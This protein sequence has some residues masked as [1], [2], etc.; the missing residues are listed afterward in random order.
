M[1]WGK[2]ANSLTTDERV[3]Q[4]GDAYSL[5]TSFGDDV[6]K[7]LVTGETPFK[8]LPRFGR[9]PGIKNFAGSQLGMPPS[10]TDK[11]AVQQTP[12]TMR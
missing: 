6:S 5:A 2:G 1:V 9:A 3:V 10:W 8:R 7:T 12:S 4:V 11:A